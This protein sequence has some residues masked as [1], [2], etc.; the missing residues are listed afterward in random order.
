MYTVEA[1]TG[2]DGVSRSS[3][4]RFARRVQPDRTGSEM[5]S[6]LFGSRPC[7]G[8]CQRASRRAPRGKPRGVFVFCAKPLLLREFKSTRF[9]ND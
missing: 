1:L 9:S 8:D 6:P 7:R 4:A 3:T 5:S 2:F